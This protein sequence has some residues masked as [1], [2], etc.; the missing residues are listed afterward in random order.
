MGKVR[1][2]PVRLTLAQQKELADLYAKH[3]AL[4]VM[5]LARRFNI[6]RRTVSAIVRDQGVTLRNGRPAIN[7]ARR[8]RVVELYCNSDRSVPDIA[9]TVGVESD[10]VH[11]VIRR[12]LSPQERQ[13]VIKRR[14][15]VRRKYRYRTDLFAEPLSDAELWLFGLLMADGSTDGRWVVKLALSVND[16]DAIESARRVAESD[17]PIVVGEGSGVS[18]GGFR[19]GPLA[20]WSIH[21]REIV[22]RVTALGMVR[23]KSYREDVHVPLAVAQSPSFWRG[24]ID[25][26]G[27]ITR[28]RRRIGDKV[29]EQPHL[30]VRGTR[31]LLVQWAAFVV[32]SIA[33]PS[34]QVRP[35][36]DTRILHQSGLAGSRAWKML[37]I[38]YGQGGPALERK[39]R[40]ALDILASRP[41]GRREIPIDLVEVALR[42][43]GSLPLGEVPRR[44][45]CPQTG[46]RLGRLL[47]YTRSGGRSDLHELF[48]RHD[49]KWRGD[50]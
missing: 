41:P 16:R 10:T 25:G 15:W 42:E 21:S 36:A 28:D 23:A 24:L 30:Q 46:V 49:P 31:A 18:R 3:P 20:W 9:A 34:P 2:Q 11:R 1:K 47:F 7:E 22:L 45:V 12:E 38:L 5:E 32:D 27:T 48:D 35:R 17:A 19:G 43:L 8:V 40:T 29:W 6:A 4:P 44:Y 50:S 13:S 39:R 14:A 37:Q 26:D 33:G